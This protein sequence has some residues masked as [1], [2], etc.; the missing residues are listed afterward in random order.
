MGHIGPA[1]DYRIDEAWMRRVGEVVGMAHNAGLKVVI[2]LHHDGST[3]SKTKEA[4]WLSITKASKSKKEY[5]R[6]TQRYIR[7]WKQIAVYFRN[8]GDWLMFESLNEIHDGGW[9]WGDQDKLDPQIKIVN[10][11]NQFCSDVVRNSGGN[12]AVRYLIFPG[13]CT[14]PRHTL[15]PYFTLPQDSVSGKQIVTFHYYEPSYF[16]IEGNESAW[17]TDSEIQTIDDDFGPFKEAFIDKGI[18][19]I[20]GETG[21]ERQLYP[22]DSDKEAEARA[23]RFA[24]IYHVFATAQKYSLVP[25]YWD[26]GAFAGG[27]ENFG[28]FNRTTGEP[29]SEDSRILIDAMIIAA[30][31]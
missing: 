31:P 2:N 26:N 22:G 27:G 12:N 28:L 21:A 3:S 8:H 25:F 17:G 4:G 1:P 30:S 9:G 29:N 13:Y 10:E 18:P 15:A 6:I 16:S 23:S 11:W 24:Y 5:N 19:V 7:V 20:I 14:S